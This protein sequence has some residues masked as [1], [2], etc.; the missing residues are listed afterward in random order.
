MVPTLVSVCLLYLVALGLQCYGPEATFISLL[1]NCNSFLTSVPVSSYL[2]QRSFHRESFN[3]QAPQ[4]TPVLLISSKVSRSIK[5]Q[6]DLPSHPP[7]NSL[8]SSLSNS[9]LIHSA[10]MFLAYTRYFLVSELLYF[11]S[12]PRNVLPLSVWCILSSL[13]VFLALVL[14][15]TYYLTLFILYI[16]M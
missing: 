6:H 13:G 16:C 3:G 9:L 7:V 11:C 2:P 5:A 15:N 4:L 1:G 10:F 12:L 14:H 8:T